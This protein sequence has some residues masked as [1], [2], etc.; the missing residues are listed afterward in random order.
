MASGRVIARN[1]LANWVGHGANLVVMFFLS[2]FIVHTLGTTQYGIWQLLTVLTGYMGILDLG[3]RAGTGRYIVLYLGKGELDKVDQ[4]IR[5]GLGTYS[6]L[7]GLIFVAGCGLGVLFPRFFPSVP[8]EYHF[9]VTVLLPVLAVNIW[10][11]AVRTVL[12]S[13]LAAYD[14]F[15]LARGSDLIMLAV[16]TVGT[17]VVLKL[18]LYLPGL[19]AAVVGCNI[20]GLLVNLFLARRVHRGLRLWPLLLNRERLG[21]LYNYGIGAFAIA[22]SVKI[23]GQT[24]LILVGNLINLDAVAVYSVGAMLLY[25]SDTFL[26]QIVTTLFPPLQR[27]VAR[28]ELGTARWLVFR[29]VR[30]AMILGLL[31]YVGYLTFGTSFIRLWMFHPETF[32]QQSVLLAGQ[33]MAILAGSKLL[34]LF[35]FGSSTILSATGHIG[36]AAKMTVLESL[37]NLA[38]S[39]AFVVLF[40]WGLAGVAAGTLAARLFTSAFVVPLYA[41]RKVGIDAWRYTMVIGGSG[42]AAG[43]LFALV[44][45]GVQ[46][47]LPANTWVEFSLQ[48]G[49][50][51][52]C[53]VPVAL[54]VLVS[55]DDRKR[56]GLRIR[57]FLP[58]T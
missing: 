54:L 53:Y 38:F 19:A 40:G 50:A 6:V 16:R 21:E 51:T 25:Y 48:V 47:L 18:G 10:V 28:G 58:G 31:M 52:A 1:L 5:T 17:V 29:Q 46:R 11:S 4:T 32:P 12:S 37:L 7:G 9:L 20:V 35:G 3:V 44:C 27:A 41:C 33:V 43:G 55:A 24:D 57:A 2:P 39:I 45:F 30:L 34:T 56:A 26:G 42:L 36:F 8:R 49:L 14:R 15:D 23:I 13:V 22:V